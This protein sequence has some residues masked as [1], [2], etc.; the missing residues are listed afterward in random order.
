M[1]ATA[2]G[3]V[4]RR[5]AAAQL[6]EA[7]TA[8]CPSSV[9]AGQQ[10]ASAAAAARLQLSRLAATGAGS[11]QQVAPAV[12]AKA[13]RLAGPVGLLAG[14]FGSI[15][16]VGGG[17]IIVPAIVSSC[18]TIPQRL[19][20]GTSL[21]AVVSTAVASA[22]TYSAQGCVDLGAA[23]LISPAAM[24]TAP[25]GARL[26]ARLNCTALRR[27]LGFFLLAAA[28]LV[29]LKAYLLSRDTAAAEESL[30]GATAD[31]GGAAGGAAAAAAALP[32]TTAA[33]GPSS[34]ASAPTELSTLVERIRFPPPATS[35]VLV[36]TGAVAGVA[37]GLLG[38]GGGL[39]VTPLLALTMDYPQATVLGTSLLAMIFPASA[40]LL[41]HQRLGNVDWRM[42][43]SLAAGTAVGSLAGSNVAVAAPPGALEAA[44]CVGMLF[45]GRKTLATAR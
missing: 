40:A 20:S 32:A 1:L 18:K 36:A 30:A 25:L 35:A 17:V 13:R 3:R 23:A 9:G 42:A 44:F 43:A 16:G 22:Y 37:S 38:V 29:P 15:V 31:A 28:P 41:Q 7:A 8:H 11:E 2:L 27:I 26:T 33:A 6:A 19:V 34:G 45:L 21:A 4:A 14:V 39:I 24:L 12:L 5:S 10:A